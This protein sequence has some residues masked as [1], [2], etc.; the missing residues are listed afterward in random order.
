MFIFSF[1]CLVS[2]KCVANNVL[3]KGS[4]LGSYYYDAIGKTCNN[5]APYAENN[6]YTLCETF[7]GKPNV[8]S[9]YNNNY[10]VAIDANIIKDREKYCGKKVVVKYNGVL[11]DKPFVAWD[12]CAACANGTRLDFSMSALLAIE[13][14]ACQLGIVPGISWEV[15]DSQVMEWRY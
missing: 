9:S 4:G 1:F 13:P 12:G 8:L 5:E 3:Y 10:L 2:S 14:N 6:G 7:L 15:I 11:V